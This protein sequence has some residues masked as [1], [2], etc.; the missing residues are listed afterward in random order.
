MAT[1]T[2]KW[3]GNDFFVHPPETNWKDAPGIYLFCGINQANQWVPLYIG[4]ASSLAER[5]ATHER[6]SEAARL[7]A[8]HIHAKVVSLQS[9]RDSIERQ[10]IQDYQPRLNVQ[11]K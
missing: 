11:L 3:S 7:G 6:W 10:L 1:Q 5:L 9:Q 4:Q 2:C 8:S